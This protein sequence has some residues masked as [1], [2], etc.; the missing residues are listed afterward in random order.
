MA[1]KMINGFLVVTVLVFF[2]VSVMDEKISLACCLNYNCVTVS[3]TGGNYANVYIQIRPD[4][5]GIAC[6]PICAH[7][8]KPSQ[9]TH[10]VPN[11]PNFVT[12]GTSYNYGVLVVTD[13]PPIQGSRIR[14]AWWQGGGSY[15]CQPWMT[16]P[17]Y[18][19]RACI[20]PLQAPGPC[21]TAP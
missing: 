14:Q 20:R 9:G 3:A 15:V 13:M 16:D 10:Y 6:S 2:V 4:L 1:S 12:Q 18:D 21:A 19:L 11:H 5:V 17:S 8:W 7:L